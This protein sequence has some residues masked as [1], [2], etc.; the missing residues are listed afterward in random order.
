M[1]K[2]RTSRASPSLRVTYLKLLPW[3]EPLSSSS[4]KLSSLYW[5]LCIV[6][7]KWSWLVCLV[8]PCDWWY[9]MLCCDRSSFTF[10]LYY[11]CLMRRKW[12]TESAGAHRRIRAVE[13][14]LRTG[15]GSSCKSNTYCQI[16][17]EMNCVF[18]RNRS[19]CWVIW[20][21]SGRWSSSAYGSKG[22][23]LCFGCP[24]SIEGSEK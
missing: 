21:S 1:N 13:A 2:W 4:P 19:R 23:L 6:D 5:L 22:S 10:S 11:S 14:S 24:L 15:F 9:C 8:S 12:L 20:M 18:T 17:T 3:S 16:A 7:V